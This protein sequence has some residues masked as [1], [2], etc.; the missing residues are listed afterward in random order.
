M[1]GV[2]TGSLE[3]QPSGRDVGRMFDRIAHRYDLLNRTLSLGQDKGWRR[4]LRRFLPDGSGLCVLDLAT[5]TGDV[6]LT[7]A[8]RRDRI[9]W[10]LGVDLAPAMLARAKQKIA[11]RMMNGSL[12]LIRGDALQLGL[13][14]N[15]FDVVTMAF[16]VRNTVEPAAALREMYRVLKPGGRVLVLEFSLP[17]NPFARALYRLYLRHVVPCVGGLISGDGEAYRYLNRTIEQF[18]HGED[19]CALLESA[20]FHTVQASPMTFGI[21]T[22]YRGDK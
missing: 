15:S 7:L 6:L 21:A 3:S 13:N 4:R 19:F 8:G 20:G 11:R 14:D 12:A 9:G 2:F 17:G 5:G 16:G 18:L 10:G 1:F 22:I